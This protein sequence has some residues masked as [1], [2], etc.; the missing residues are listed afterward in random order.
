MK[1]EKIR[2]WFRCNNKEKI[3]ILILLIKKRYFRIVYTKG[4]LKKYIPKISKGDSGLV[5]LIYMKNQ[6]DTGYGTWRRIR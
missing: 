4:Y 6:L 5:K 2:L 1:F 3:I